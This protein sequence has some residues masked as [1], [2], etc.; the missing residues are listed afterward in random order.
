[1]TAARSVLSLVEHGWRA[2]RECALA[3]LPGGCAVTHLVRGTL[4][5]AVRAVIQLQPGEHLIGVPR[6][7]YRMTRLGFFAVA[8]LSRREH[9]VLADNERTLKETA[10]WCRACGWTPVLAEEVENRCIYRVGGRERT[11][12]EIFGLT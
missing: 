10:W 2:A 9:W 8:T 12:D 6:L 7:L 5:P 3:V 1:M 11:P 4:P